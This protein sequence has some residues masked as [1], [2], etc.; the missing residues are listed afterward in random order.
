MTP[1]RC[2]RPP[3]PICSFSPVGSCGLTS[4]LPIYS[5]DASPSLHLSSSPDTT[6]WAL[7]EEEMISWRLG[8]SGRRRAGGGR[9]GRGCSS[10]SWDS[11]SQKELRPHQIDSTQTA[12]VVLQGRPNPTK[13]VSRMVTRNTMQPS[14]S[15]HSTAASTPSLPP[16]APSSIVADMMST[17][18]GLFDMNLLV[19]QAATSSNSPIDNRSTS[20]NICPAPS[21]SSVLSW[22]R[23]N[24]PP[25][26]NTCL[27]SPQFDQNASDESAAMR[28]CEEDPSVLQT[29]GVQTGAQDAAVKPSTVEGSASQP[30]QHFYKTKMCPWHSRGQCRM[31]EKCNWSH[32][33]QDLRPCVDLSKTKL[34]PSLF[35]GGRCTNSSCRYAHSRADLR[36]TTD[37]FKTSLCS[38]WQQGKCSVGDA[39]RYAHGSHDLRSKPYDPRGLSTT[40]PLCPP[41][42]RSPDLSTI[43][44]AKSMSTRSTSMAPQGQHQ[45]DFATNLLLNAQQ[46]LSCCTESPTDQSHD[47]YHA[48]TKGGG[49]LDSRSSSRI[50]IS[51]DLFPHLPPPMLHSIHHLEPPSQHVNFSSLFSSPHKIAGA[52]QLTAETL[53]ARPSSLLFP[54]SPPSPTSSTVSL[55]ATDVHLASFAVS[56]ATVPTTPSFTSPRSLQQNDSSA[57][58][59]RKLS[60]DSVLED[61]CSKLMMA[62]HSSS[63][64]YSGGVDDGSSLAQPVMSS[65]VLSP[66]PHHR[67][68]LFVDGSSPFTPTTAHPPTYLTN[69][70]H[71]IHDLFGSSSVC[72]QSSSF[73]LAVNNNTYFATPPSSSPFS[74][75]VCP[76]PSAH[77]STAASVDRSVADCFLS[78]LEE[79]QQNQPGFGESLMSEVFPATGRQGGGEDGQET[80]WRSMET[81]LVRL[82]SS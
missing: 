62:T 39:C 44:K 42:T 57:E 27:T 12:A 61:L 11:A 41:T 75:S 55:A 6:K 7:R 67:H 15:L 23:P 58:E 82:I 20:A 45:I 65:C 13:T 63:N 9:K 36:A 54:S 10:G 18:P 77:S 49:A 33:V 35:K 53:A 29:D 79:V 47:Y 78:L 2:L 8:R 56:S 50:E 71:Q 17:P 30:S 16:V 46:N 70:S 1:P 31:A 43:Q 52:S 4:D 74:Y 76:P 21:T 51:A 64:E 19:A 60:M 38:F 69:S 3:S 37:V 5:T 59:S 72:K 24:G 14:T 26:P 40:Q 22:G 25:H 66:P 73:S 28:T 48:S 32:G 81:S 68:S 34:C 80:I